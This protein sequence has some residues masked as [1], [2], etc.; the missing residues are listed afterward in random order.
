MGLQKKIHGKFTENPRTIHEK[1]TANFTEKFTV[2]FSRSS[3]LA[4]LRPARSSLSLIAKAKMLTPRLRTGRLPRTAQS[5]PEA[6]FVR[7]RGAPNR[8]CPSPNKNAA[9]GTQR[10]FSR[11]LSIGIRQRMLRK[12]RSEWQSNAP[13]C[14]VMQCH[15]GGNWPG[16]LG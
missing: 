16:A 7:E 15:S 4:S 9:L 14:L 6:T 8:A 5:T 12:A 2:V 1:F 11:S 3:A 13:C 10:S